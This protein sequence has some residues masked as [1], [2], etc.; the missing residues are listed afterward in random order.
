MKENTPAMKA[1]RKETSAMGREGGRVVRPGLHY[2]V[3]LSGITSARGSGPKSSP[4]LIGGRS[5][6]MKSHF[7]RS[8]GFDACSQWR[9]ETGREKPIVAS[10]AY[11]GFAAPSSA[12]TASRTAAAE[13][14]AT[15]DPNTTPSFMKICQS[16]P[17][18]P[19]GV[20]TREPACTWPVA[21][22][23]VASF[24]TKAEPGSAMSA[25][26]ASGVLSTPCTMSVLIFPA[27]RAAMIQ[28]VSPIEPSGPGSKTY[29]TF[30]W[31]LSTADF[32]PDTSAG[33]P[34]AAV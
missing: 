24:S 12:A 1:A 29:S 19:G 23:Y 4:N 9:A 34:A 13:A 33:A 15:G 27:W 2:L 5:W 22:V 8:D 30:T 6:N 32:R 28:S 18:S 31:P 20:M 10:A 16:S 7:Q 3:S 11:P 21:F 14:N 17:A 26:S 25:A